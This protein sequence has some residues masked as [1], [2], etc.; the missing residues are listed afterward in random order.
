M[1]GNMSYRVSYRE[2]RRKSEMQ[3]GKDAKEM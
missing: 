3:E 2:S 1:K